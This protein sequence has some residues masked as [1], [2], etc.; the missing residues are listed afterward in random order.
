MDTK[1]KLE[2][3]LKE[4]FKP[5]YLKIEDQSALHTGHAE[6]Q[7]S[8]GGHFAV[9][10]VARSFAGKSLIERHRSVNEVLKK[11]QQKEV[12]ALAIKAFTPD[13]FSTRS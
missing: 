2:I 6:A 11:E 3:I 1:T 4:K 7:K 8:G 5:S 13:E 10:I 12:H 9:T